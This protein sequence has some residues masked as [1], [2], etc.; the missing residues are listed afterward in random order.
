MT[1]KSDIETLAELVK[2]FRFAM[3]TT[4]DDQGQLVA[5]P[6]TVQEAEFDGDLWFIVGAHASSLENLLVNPSAGVSLSSND[7]WVSLTGT[8]G[9][10]DDRAK[11]K[12]LWGSTLEAWFPEG[13]DDPNVRLLKFTAD[14]AE[15]WDSPGGKVATLFSLVKS[16]VTGETYE[17]ENAKIEL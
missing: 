17:G 13:P 1:E 8:A 11:V 12:E 10:V 15:Y 7:A 9:V 4:V 14:G 16:K 6:L 2:K 5:H 3:L